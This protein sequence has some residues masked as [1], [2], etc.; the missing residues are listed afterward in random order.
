MRQADR[1]HALR[2]GGGAA[3]GFDGVVKRRLAGVAVVTATTPAGAAASSG[4][5]LPQAVNMPAKRKAPSAGRVRKR[6]MA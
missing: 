4:A 5:A 1:A 2:I 3:P 6:F